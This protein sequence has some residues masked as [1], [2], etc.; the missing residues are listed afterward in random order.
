VSPVAAVIRN[1]VWVIFL[2]L[3][4]PCDEG[5]IK[6]SLVIYLDVSYHLNSQA[7]RLRLERLKRNAEI[8]TGSGGNAATNR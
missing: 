7:G 6:M 4:G 3:S 8:E 2:L 1:F 5:R